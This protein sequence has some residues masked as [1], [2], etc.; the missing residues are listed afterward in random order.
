MVLS[1]IQAPWRP[2]WSYQ[3]ISSFL[4]CNQWVGLLHHHDQLQSHS[5][6]DTQGTTILSVAYKLHISKIAMNSV[7]ELAREA[8]HQPVFDTDAHKFLIDSGASTHLW[9]RCQDFSSYH[10]LSC[11]EQEPDKVLGVNGKTIKPIG[12]GTVLLKIEDD[13]NHVHALEIQDVRHMPE[14]LLN[15]FV[16]QALIQQQQSEGDSVASCSINPTRITLKWMSESGR[17]ASK[18]VPLNR[19]N[20]DIAFTASGYTNFKA[21]AAM[22]AMPATYVSDD[23]DDAIPS[24]SLDEQPICATSPSPHEDPVCSPSD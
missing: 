2:T 6:K 18:Y 3:R 16:P 22:F 14:I 10:R 9:N 20:I 5:G 7:K 15:I 17:E 13:L 11:E 12:M 19:S 21:F 23:E 8:P 4:L 24:S 1:A